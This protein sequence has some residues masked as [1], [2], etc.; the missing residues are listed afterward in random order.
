MQ[1][2]RLARA[3]A[4]LLSVLL[5][6]PATSMLYCD[7]ILVDGYGFNLEKLG[8]PHSVVTTLREPPSY[9]NTTYTVDICKPLKKSGDAPKNEQCP[10]GTRVCAIQRTYNGSSDSDDSKAV[11]HKVVPIAGGRLYPDTKREGLRLTLKGGAYPLDVPHQEQTRQQAIIDFICDPDKEGT[12]NEWDATDDKYDPDGGSDEEEGKKV[13]RANGE[14]QL[15]KE[16]AALKFLG[17]GKDSDSDWETLRLE[18]RTKHAC[19]S[20]YGGTSAS[21]GFFTWLF[22]IAFMGIAAYLIFGS[23][24]NY[25]RYGARGWDLVPHGD[26]I[27]DIPYLMKDWTRSVLNTVQGSGSRGGYSAV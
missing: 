5:A 3:D 27:R 25:N 12:E 13:R 16:G 7:N 23:W 19:G 1:I 8:G 9:S 20:A 22:I 2:P 4:L 6:T 26:A 14:K 15:I 11:V 10:N 17:Y 24:L 18:W 21:W